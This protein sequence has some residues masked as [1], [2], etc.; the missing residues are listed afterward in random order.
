[1]TMNI[2]NLFTDEPTVKKIRTRLPE[3]FYLAELDSSRA[4]KVGMEVGSVREKILIA[5]LIYRFGKENVETKIPIT[6]REVDVI[7]FGQPVSIKTIT[8]QRL[9]GV[10]LSWT[11]DAAQA[12]KFA[13]EF[14]PCCDILLAQINWEDLGALFYFP[15]DVQ[16][17]TMQKIG[18]QNYFKLPKPGTNP[19]GVEISVEALDLF[20]S[21]PKSLSLQVKWYRTNVD[22][23]PYKRWLELWERD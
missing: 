11:V 20:L 22:Y 6:E 4:G 1:M 17:E 19:R 5:L 9:G 12:L 18:R 7:V 3:L 10:K 16:A 8:G 14:N 13:Q 21:H 15:L 2:T 23:D